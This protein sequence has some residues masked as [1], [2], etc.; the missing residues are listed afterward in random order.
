M[1]EG[2]FEKY[3]RVLTQKKNEKEEVISLLQELSNITFSEEELFIEKKIIIFHTS[4]VKKS[5]VTQKN[6]QAKI[7]EKGYSIK[8]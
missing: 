3:K 4:S 1:H 7:L 6:I 8:I 2:L 5:I